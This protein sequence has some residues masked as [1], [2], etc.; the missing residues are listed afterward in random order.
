MQYK[1]FSFTVAAIL[2]K[3]DT[4]FLCFSALGHLILK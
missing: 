3:F 4:L 1:H 2:T